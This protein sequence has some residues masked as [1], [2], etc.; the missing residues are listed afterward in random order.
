MKYFFSFV[1]IVLFSFLL[2]LYMSWWS[3]AVVAFCVCMCLIKKPLWAFVTGFVSILLL[4][5]GLAWYISA[6]NNH[7]LAH[8]ISLLV[9]RQDN[10]VMLIGLSAFIGALTAGF[11]GLSGTLLGRLVFEKKLET[12]EV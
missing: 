8:K 12:T 3:V 2:S 9:L 5:G 4:W 1:L 10:P 7:V 11:A 6:G